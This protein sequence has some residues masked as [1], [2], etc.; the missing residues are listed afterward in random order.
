MKQSLVG[1]GDLDAASVNKEVCATFRSGRTRSISWRID[2]LKAIGRLLEEREAEIGD[3]LM[4]DLGKSAFES[5]CTEIVLLTNSCK[6]M[7]DN[8]KKW[9]GPQKVSVPLALQPGSGTVVPEPLGAVLIFSAWNFP[10]M[11]ALDPLIGAVAAGNTVVLK[12]S[13]IA[14]ATSSL[15]NKLIPIYLDPSAVKVVEGGIAEST[16]LLEQRWEKIFYTGSPQVGRIIMGAAAKH[17]TPVTLELGGKCPAIIDSTADIEVAARRI[18]SGKWGINCGQA[19]LAPDYVLAEEKIAPKL[20]T[21]LKKTLKDFYSMDPANSPDLTRIV[22]NRHFLRLKNMLEFPG[23]AEAV[24]HGGK[25]KEVKLFIEPTILLNPPLDAAVMTE[26]IFGPLLPIVTIPTII[27]AIDFVNSR[28]K[29]LALYLFTNDEDVKQKVALETSAGGML[30]NDTVVHFGVTTMPFGGVGE[31]GMGSYHGK[32]SFDTF[33][34]MKPILYRTCGKD[35]PTRYP[36]Y[37]HLKQRILRSLLRFDY[38]GVLL[39][40]LGLK[41]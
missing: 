24:V 8:L 41:H 22:N 34:H 2:Q 20:I 9:T 4:H 17:L 11:L 19:C 3:S 36:P 26:E 38:I 18:A 10:L 29:P 7:S 16:A 40:L 32:H 5:Y 23:T 39:I 6:Y 15:L 13:E 21:V 35:V 30:V 28:E 12:P 33:S 14:P 37:T 27:E 25:W 1:M 31:S